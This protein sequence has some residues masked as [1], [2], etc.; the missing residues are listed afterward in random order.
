MDI[1]SIINTQIN[2]YNNYIKKY[3]NDKNYKF[4]KKCDMYVYH[5]LTHCDNCATCDYTTCVR[6]IIP[7]RKLCEI[8]KCKHC[9]S[10]LSSKIRQIL[11][12]ILIYKKI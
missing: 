6:S 11:F 7:G 12:F 2:Q 5:E 3:E 4:C 10:E 9:N 8:R 1:D